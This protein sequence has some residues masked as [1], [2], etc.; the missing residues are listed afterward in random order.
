[1]NIE[2][3]KSFCGSCKGALGDYLSSAGPSPRNIQFAFVK[4]RYFP[5]VEYSLAHFRLYK[6]EY[7]YFSLTLLRNVPLNILGRNHTLYWV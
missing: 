1:M 5:H 3:H 2:T 7:S 4:L 6:I